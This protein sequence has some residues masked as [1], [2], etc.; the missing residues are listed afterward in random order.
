[1]AASLSVEGGE[2]RPG[3][4]AARYALNPR[5]CPLLEEAVSG[6]CAGEHHPNCTVGQRNHVV[7]LSRPDRS[8]TDVAKDLQGRCVLQHLNVARA[9]V[10]PNMRQ[11]PATQRPFV[12]PLDC[13]PV[14]ADDSV[15]SARWRL[16]LGALGALI[17]G[18]TV[19]KDIL[20]T[21]GENVGGHVL[22]LKPVVAATHGPI[23][24]VVMAAGSRFT[25]GSLPRDTTLR[26]GLGEDAQS[27]VTGTSAH[28]VRQ[29]DS[30]ARLNPLPRLLLEGPLA[31]DGSSANLL[32]RATVSGLPRVK[33]S[34]NALQRLPSAD[35]GLGARCLK[36]VRTPQRG[37]AAFHTEEEG[38]VGLSRPDAVASL[39]ELPGDLSIIGARATLELSVCGDPGPAA[40]RP[41]KLA[42]PPAVL[43]IPK[44]A[45]PGPGLGGVARRREAGEVTGGWR[46]LRQA[47]ADCLGHQWETSAIVL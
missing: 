5:R 24:T 3:R 4:A 12:V 13:D 31:S 27:V 30:A 28:G 17:E 32:A 1:M 23:L 33:P 15:A 37:A 6:F 41:T 39:D 16:V 45:L 34:G 14:A 38:G 46:E 9:S 43:T 42:P 35:R 40:P 47:Q 10:N 20:L 44:M 25:L 8:L 19:P 36:L 2:A 22:A 29:R 7:A 21:L 18:T 11:A 26:F